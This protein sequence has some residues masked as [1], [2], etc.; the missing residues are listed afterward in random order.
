MEMKS[1]NFDEVESAYTQKWV[2]LKV[3]YSDSFCPFFTEW[4]RRTDSQKLLREL[5]DKIRNEDGGIYVTVQTMSVE[6]IKGVQYGLVE[7]EKK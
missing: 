5:A 1:M 7:E 2:R 3:M 4:V 6:V